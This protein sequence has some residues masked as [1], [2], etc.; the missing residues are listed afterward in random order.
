VL[1]GVRLAITTWFRSH[2]K[3]VGHDFRWWV[4]FIAHES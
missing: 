3:W 2:C 1:W 4:C